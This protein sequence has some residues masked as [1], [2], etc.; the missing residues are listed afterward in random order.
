MFTGFSATAIVQSSSATTVMVVSFVNA[1]LL[2]LRQAIST[3]MGA[4]IGTTGEDGASTPGG[5]RVPH[6]R[7]LG[8]HHRTGLPLL[9]MRNAR[10]KAFSE[11]LI[12]FGP[13]H[14]DSTT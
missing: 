12:G 6:R 14:Q 9:F 8:A 1:G 4:N 11:F 3:I 2:N 13:F 10:A 7:P 5:R